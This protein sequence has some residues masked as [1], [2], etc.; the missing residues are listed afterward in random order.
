VNR[1]QIDVPPPLGYVM[2]VADA[3]SG[4]RLL[5][6]DFTLLSHDFFKSFRYLTEGLF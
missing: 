4:L 2:R 5:A 6:A 3:V 1:A